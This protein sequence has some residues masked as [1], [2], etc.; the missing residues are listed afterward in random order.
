MHLFLKLRNLLCG[1][2]VFFIFTHH[3][4]LSWAQEERS[5]Q[6]GFRWSWGVSTVTAVTAAAVGLSEEDCLH[7]Y[8]LDSFLDSVQLRT[9]TGVTNDRKNSPIFYCV[10]TRTRYLDSQRA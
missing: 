2:V 7:R 4:F 1:G 6:K 9:Q 10:F 3:A 8:S 5:F